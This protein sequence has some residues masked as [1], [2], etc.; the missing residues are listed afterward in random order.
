MEAMMKRVM[1]AEDRT[2]YATACRDRA[3]LVTGMVR[4]I[5]RRGTGLERWERAD[6]LQ[7]AAWRLWDAAKS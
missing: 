7:A 3:I 2:F 1:T 5:A 6:R 4:E